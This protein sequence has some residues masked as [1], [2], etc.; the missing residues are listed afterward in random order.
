MRRFVFSDACLD[1]G[2]AITIGNFD[3]LHLGHQTMLSQLK[4]AAKARD[5]PT[6]VV[7]FEPQPMEYF[8]K[9]SSPARLMSFRQK[10]ESIR[11]LGID[12]VI[13]LSF[14]KPLA[15]LSA[16][17]FV[18]SILCQKIKA[19]YVLVGQDFKFGHKRQGN[20]QLLS[21]LSDEFGFET[22]LCELTEQDSEKVSSTRVRHALTQGDLT[23]AKQLLG[24]PYQISG[25]VKHGAKR[26]RLIGVPTANIQIKHLPLT[27]RG[28][29]SVEVLHNNTTYSGVANVGFRPTVSGNTPQLEAHL[30]DFSGDLYG[31]RIV[32]SFIQKIRNEQKFES[33]EAL[34]TQ[35]KQDIIT[36]QQ[37][38]RISHEH[39]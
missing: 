36:A 35:I 10:V 9:S 14:N 33:F 3:G 4:K 24:R 21:E 5:L 23:T 27:L 31:Q 19:R 7:L 32:V 39:L 15:L 17:R 16:R 20:T 38:L 18:E 22:A 28:V 1:N 25:R 8:N 12:A 2:C 13:C 26:G 29:F 37:Q 11:E 34:T 30:F 6:M